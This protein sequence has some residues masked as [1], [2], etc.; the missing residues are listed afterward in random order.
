MAITI[1]IPNSVGKFSFLQTLLSFTLDG[2]FDDSQSERCIVSNK[3][4]MQYL[5]GI[6]ETT[7][8]SQF[9][10]KANYSASQ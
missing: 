3:P 10:L 9:I 6:S 4:K 2:F 5:S 1:C 7:K 8:L